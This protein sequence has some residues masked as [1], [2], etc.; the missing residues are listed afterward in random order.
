MG[1]R[2]FQTGASTCLTI[3]LGL[4]EPGDLREAK[5]FIFAQVVSMK[6]QVEEMIQ[7]FMQQQQSQLDMCQQV[8][9][10]CPQSSLFPGI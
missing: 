5:P 4:S 8:P 1:K 10:L 3:A 9:V 7:T 2:G 6:P